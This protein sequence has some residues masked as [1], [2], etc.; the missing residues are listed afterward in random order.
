LW[1]AAGSQNRKWRARETTGAPASAAT[2]LLTAE[3]A[4]QRDRLVVVAT[5]CLDEEAIIAAAF[6]PLFSGWFF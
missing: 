4:T 6:S 5:A 1:C 3:T 2:G